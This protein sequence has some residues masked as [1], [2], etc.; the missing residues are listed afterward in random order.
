MGHID[1]LVNESTISINNNE[2]K[3]GKW[4]IRIIYIYS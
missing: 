1:Y 4:I 2:F 3:I